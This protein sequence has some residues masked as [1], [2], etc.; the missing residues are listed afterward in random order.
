MER[1]APLISLLATWTIFGGLHL[2]AWNFP[3][4][5]EVEKIAWRVASLC[6]TGAP[7]VVLVVIGLTRDEDEGGKN[8]I[9][10]AA[11]TSAVLYAVACRNVLLTLMFASLR[12]IPCSAFQIVQWTSYIPHL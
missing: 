3:F 9:R 10:V 6:L 7:L 11:L 5:T 12:A 2:T 1:G 4:V 8:P